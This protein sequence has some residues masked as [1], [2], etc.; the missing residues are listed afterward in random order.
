[1]LVVDKLV[2]QRE[3]LF[4]NVIYGPHAF[5]LFTYLDQVLPSFIRMAL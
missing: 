5:D 1:M 4:D 2:R 3:H